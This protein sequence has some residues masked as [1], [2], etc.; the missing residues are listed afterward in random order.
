M[1]MV[2]DTVAV[3]KTPFK[4]SLDTPFYAFVNWMHK[5]YPKAL[6]FYGSYFTIRSIY[7]IGSTLKHNMKN[8]NLFK[9]DDK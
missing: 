6:I 2:K 9:L 3:T 8:A 7:G 1:T 5:K 4:R